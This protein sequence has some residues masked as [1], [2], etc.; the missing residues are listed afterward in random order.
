MIVLLEPQRLVNAGSSGKTRALGTGGN[1]Q[2]CEIE[3]LPHASS[4]MLRESDSMLMMN[5]RRPAY[6]TTE[7]WA[8]SILLETGAIREC[9]THGWM[10]DSADPH[11]RE[12]S[13]IIAREDPPLGIDPDQAVAPVQDLLDSIGDTCPE[14]P[15]DAD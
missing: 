2:A 14:C 4:F 10:R 13:L 7:G 15:P 1:H 9:E 3:S 8:R 5:E 12:R 6:R 11:A